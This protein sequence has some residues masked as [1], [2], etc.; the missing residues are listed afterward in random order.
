MRPNRDTLYSEA[1]VD[2]DAGPVTITLPDA[3]TRYMGLQVI[4]EDHY[5]RHLLYEPGGYTYTK[6][7]VGTRYMF[8][9]VR[10]LIDPAN[11]DD[12]KHVHAL[13]DSMTIEQ[14]D[15]PGT[16]EIPRWQEASRNTVKA[17]LQA[18]GGT[19]PDLKRAFGTRDTVDPV[20][21]LI[22]VATGWGGNPDEDAIYLNVTPRNNDG[23]S[24]YRL[25]VKDVPVDGFWSI[26]VYNGEGHFVQNALN[27]Y[28]L[29]GVTA[30]KESDGSVAIQF[31]GCDD[32][33][34]NC[35]P[36]FPGWNYMVRLYRPRKEILDGTF[37]FPEAQLAA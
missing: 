13:Q 12:L 26:S 20:R 32:N 19:L 17:A 3:G 14:P 27:A 7:D 10:T 16:F 6:K 15:G 11:P 36:I 30:K 4:D 33:A 9:A 8:A 37:T 24:I 31:G 23:R 5:A 28:T 21:H 22:G 29:N 18:L 2:L 35:L 25:T 1:V 34:A